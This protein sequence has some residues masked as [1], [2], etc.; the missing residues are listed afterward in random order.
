MRE[1]LREMKNNKA[2]GI[3]EINVDML[4]A[5]DLMWLTEEEPNSWNNS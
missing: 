5:G 2:P 3:S 1:A 4:K